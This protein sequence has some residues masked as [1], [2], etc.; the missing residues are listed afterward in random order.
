MDSLIQSLISAGLTDKEARVYIALLSL[1][2]ASAYSV[3][4]K[5]NLKKPTTYVILEELIEKGLAM[6][7]PRAK[8]QQYVARPPEEFFATA[9]ERL[10]Q[11]R[12]ALPQL[13]ALAESGE[14]QKIRTLFFEGARGIE[15]AL[16]YRKEEMHGKEMIG[17]YA[18]AEQAD[19]ELLAI[20]NPYP[21]HMADAGIR[22]RGITPEHDSTKKIVEIDEALGF[23]IERVPYDTY[24]SKA[25]I[26]AGDTFI[27]IILNKEKQAVVIENPELAEAVRQIFE[28]VW[29]E[30]NRIQHNTKI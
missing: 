16:Y 9:E 30:R 28:I 26:E 6:K 8:K 21:K 4:S 15:E 19:E 13:Q 23:S 1:G 27:R 3:S 29:K 14:K 5:S 25:S 22:L 7:V 2:R 18:T 20:Y 11:A 17:F 24:S 12:R 10:K